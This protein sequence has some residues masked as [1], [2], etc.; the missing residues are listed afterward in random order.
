M[1]KKLNI[2]LPVIQA[3]FLSFIV[4]LSLNHISCKVSSEGIQVLSGDYESPELQSVCVKSDSEIAV[5]FSEPVKVCGISLCE[6]TDMQD[7]TS[8]EYLS[9]RPASMPLCVVPSSDGKSFVCNLSVPTQIGR[10]YILFGQIEDENGNSLTFTAPVTGYNSRA[11]AV[12]FS[13]FQDKSTVLGGC[14][15]IELYVLEPGNLAGLVISSAN[16]GEEFD[17]SLP[18]VEVNAKEF[19]VVHLRNTGDGCINEIGDELDLSTAPGSSAGRDIWI[20][21][22]EN[23]LGATQDVIL[24]YDENAG[25]V[26]DAFLYSRSTKIEWTKPVY[27][28][29]AE[30]ACENGIWSEGSGFEN[31]FMLNGSS[32]Q[33]IFVRTN[34]EQLEFM[35]E[36]GTLDKNCIPVCKNDW[37]RISASYVTPGYAK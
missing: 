18:P 6:A 10:K 11:A 27:S 12:V 21:N 1:K 31:V 9:K 26:K 36:S 32:V 33:G 4:F 17:V 28:I 14:E 15:F 8:I 34:L 16:D 24:L 7:M 22:T 13:E 23:R 2:F 19:V 29:S 3:L 25:L 30:K 37:K 5:N 20:N 35:A